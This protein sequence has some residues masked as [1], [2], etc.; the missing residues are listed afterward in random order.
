M[1][2]TLGWLATVV[3]SPEVIACA[4]CR[5]PGRW[6]KRLVVRKSK[7]RFGRGSE[8]RAHEVVARE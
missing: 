3:H 4:L 6:K 2:R 7:C 8:V 5:S 1:V